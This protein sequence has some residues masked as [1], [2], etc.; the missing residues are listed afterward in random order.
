[1]TATSSSVSS[2][3]SQSRRALN[4]RSFSKFVRMAHVPPFSNA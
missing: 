4:S 3:T 1:M 2:S